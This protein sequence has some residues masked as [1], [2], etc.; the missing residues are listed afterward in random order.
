MKRPL[1]ASTISLLAV[2]AFAVAPAS[3]VERTLTL[4]PQSTEVTFVLDATG[5][6]VHG[7]LHLKEGVIRFDPET[8][9]ASGD[10]VIDARLAETGNKKRDKTMHAKVLESG[11]HPLMEFHP[12]TIRGEL[13]LQGQSKVELVGTVELVGQQHPLAMPATIDIDGDTV[14]ATAAFPVPFI[15]WGL[16]DPSNFLLKVAKQV[17]VSVTAHGRLDAS[18]PAAT[19]AARR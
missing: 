16:H 3:A 1:L 11:A 6:D 14:T 9:T 15:E 12:Q 4:D 13:A 7:I 17:E 18:S 19:A 10:V 8:Y 5:H 2:A